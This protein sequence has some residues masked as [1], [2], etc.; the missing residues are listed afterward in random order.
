MLSVKLTQK[1]EYWLTYKTHVAFALIPAIPIADYS[2]GL[3][4][5]ESIAFLSALSIGALSPDLDEEGSYLSRKIPVMPMVFKLFGVKHRAI[6]HRL[7]AVVFLISVYYAFV[8]YEPSIENVSY[9]F[10]GFI[11]G[12]LMHL[13][14]DMLT[15][16]GINEF[17]YPF[18]NIR[19]VLLPRNLRFFTGSS[20]E[21]KVF[22]IIISIVISEILYLLGFLNG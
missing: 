16:G 19:G 15:K 1:K 6:T 18:S 17:F 3:L 4:S 21:F 8:L 11:L 12:Y 20:N 2:Y 14:G 13:F 10:Y 5:F 7:I 9:L 22:F